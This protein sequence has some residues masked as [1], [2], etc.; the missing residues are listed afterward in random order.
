MAII[1]LILL[2]TAV[3]GDQICIGYHS[4]NSTEK[5]DTILERNVTVTHAQDILEKTHNGKLCKLNGIPPLELG[6]CSIAGWLLGNPECD[7]FLTVPEW[8][9]IMEKENPRNRSV[10]PRQFQ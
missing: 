7:R 2:F 9:Y 1:Y 5:V 8:S 6:D 3:K 4:N 10:L